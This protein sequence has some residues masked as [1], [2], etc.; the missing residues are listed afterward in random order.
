[1]AFFAR[2]ILNIDNRGIVRLPIYALANLPNSST[3]GYLA[4][5]QDQQRLTI[6]T[7]DSTIPWKTF[8]TVPADYLNE[9][10]I[11]QGVIGGGTNGPSVYNNMSK[12][13]FASDA[14]IQLNTTLPFTQAFG[15][16]HSTWQYA[17]YH[18]GNSTQSAKQDWATFTVASITSRP[19]ISGALGASLNPGTK[20][21]NTYGV[22][23]SGGTSNTLNFSTDVWISNNFDSPVALDYGTFGE[24]Y[25]YGMS[26]SAG[27]VYK[28]SWSSSSWA[29]TGSGVSNGN[30]N[31]KP[32]NTKWNKWY[33]GGPGSTIDIY[34]NAI[35]TFTN[36]RST[37]GTFQ[38]Q[39]SAMGQD[40]GYWYGYL[41]GYNGN[42]YKTSYTV[43]ATFYPPRSPLSYSASS[44]SAT[45]GPIA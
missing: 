14:G 16:Q 6:S 23:M 10:V 36:S 44:A 1:M 21:L 12:V 7:G 26:F 41:G 35:D 13:H 34:N 39:A 43:D 3:A 15:G 45:S 25:G 27:T 2:G 11:E 42:A 38:N 30:A 9:V 22:V 32:L 17:Y 37:P 18:S 33:Q 5:V 31:S 28:L 24:T 4:Y 40:W 8:L 19:G 29:A 20:G